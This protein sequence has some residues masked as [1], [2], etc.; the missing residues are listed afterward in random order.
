MVR[1]ADKARV[2][3]PLDRRALL[4]AGGLSLA[5]AAALAACGVGAG[6]GG[7]EGVV[8]TTTTT[9]PSPSDIAI[10]QTATTLEALAIEIY[11]QATDRGVLTTPAVVEAAELLAGHHEEHRTLFAGETSKLDARPDTG[12]NAALRSR[13]ADRI[14]GMASEDD[15]LRLALDLERALAATYQD[16]TGDLMAA[17]LRIR[18]M[19]VGGVEARHA[20]LVAAILGEPLYP[21]DGFQATNGA[22]TT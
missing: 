5:G 17:D 9:E 22:V 4:K 11:A 3:V 1:S 18:L 21:A 15:A 14:A 19:S 7:E 6:G 2:P 10:L 12:V 13:F 16:N 8:A 20:A